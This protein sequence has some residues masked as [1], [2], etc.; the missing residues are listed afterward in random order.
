MSL[1]LQSMTNW[2][3]VKKGL[4]GTTGKAFDEKVLT[5]AAKAKVFGHDAAIDQIGIQ[6][7]R[8]IGRAQAAGGKLQKP[9]GVFLLSGP[10]CS[11][12]SLF[13]K[14]ATEKIYDGN[15]QFERLVMEQFMQPT[16]R[17]DLFG[18]PAGYAGG[19]G[20]VT[21]ALQ[22]NPRTVFELEGIEKAHTEVLRIL[23]TG[24]KDSYFTDIHS[25]ERVS[26][27][28]AIFFLTTTIAWEQLRQIEEA[29]K[30]NPMRRQDAIHDALVQG[31]LGMDLVAR[32]DD[33][34]VFEPLDNR[35]LARMAEA[36][37]RQTV[38][39]YGLTVTKI[40]VKYLFNLVSD[41]ESRTGAIRNIGRRVDFEL[42]DQFLELGQKGVKSVAI[43]LE[44][45]RAIVRDSATPPPPL[46]TT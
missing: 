36:E 10:P 5:T 4:G 30:G 13:C 43:T 16:A 35:S 22:R 15:A 31:G 38:A 27:T 40:D 20:K 2:D 19:K 8:C 7:K 44:D 9:T 34:F 21:S 33:A 39:V 1:N 23:Q 3:E 32:L 17:T 12:K 25:S 29:H 41:E 37:I 24:W 14:V 42:A 28:D 18:S 11:G 46:P 26:N 6:L 45:G